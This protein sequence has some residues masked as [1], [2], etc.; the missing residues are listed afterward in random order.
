MDRRIASILVVG[1]P[2][3]WA[4]L[5]G[6]LHDRYTAVN[7]RCEDINPSFVDSDVKITNQTDGFN[8]LE[9]SARGRHFAYVK[10]TSTKQSKAPVLLMHGFPDN[11]HSFKRLMWDLAERGH[12]SYAPALRGFVITPTL[13]SSPTN[14]NIKLSQP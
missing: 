7:K 13:I 10:H 11:H 6:V 3:L 1:G 2:L 4:V 12:N 14:P 8:E 9:I 5:F